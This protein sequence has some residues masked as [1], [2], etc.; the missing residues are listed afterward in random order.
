MKS[1]VT[2]LQSIYAV[3]G[4]KNNTQSV[5]VQG[6]RTPD[7]RYFTIFVTHTHTHTQ[8]WLASIR[9]RSNG[10]IP[11]LVP[12]A[13]ARFDIVGFV[14]I[15]RYQCHQLRIVWIIRRTWNN[16]DGVW[17]LETQFSVSR[18]DRA[19]KRDIEIYGLV[20]INANYRR[21]SIPLKA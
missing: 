6:L 19:Q 9:A 14:A 16:D 2:Y 17:R 1:Y 7:I 12:T 5:N 18:L 3:S 13:S 8:V 15:F 10:E 20:M 21:V 11:E 4:Y